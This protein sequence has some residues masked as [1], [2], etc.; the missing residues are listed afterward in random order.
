TNATDA[1]TKAYVDAQVSGT[2]LNTP[3]TVVKRDST[4]SFAAQVVSVVDSVH[5]GNLI[6]SVEPSTAT[7]GNILKGSSR[8][9]HDFGTANLFV[10]I[11]AGNFTT[12]GTGNNVG[13]GASALTANTTGASNTAVGS[14]ALAANTVGI[15]N[16]AVGRNALTV[17]TTGTD[18][19]EIGFNALDANATGTSN[20]TAVGSSALA[21]N[22]TGTNNTAIGLNA[23][24]ICTTGST[25]IA[26]G[27][28]AG[29]TLT[30]GSGNIY[31]NANAG[32]AAE[33]TTTR[34]GTS[35]NR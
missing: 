33:A 13:I 17:N 14:S 26:L 25:N 6:L 35:Q 9:I 8:F 29:G 7:T 20:N 31:I 21:A 19:T 10:G 4:G 11:N 1:A 23:L 15:N 5:S 22:T 12:S 27:S 3:D 18:N 34:I 30:T 24:S 32:V 16:T 28:G 2:N